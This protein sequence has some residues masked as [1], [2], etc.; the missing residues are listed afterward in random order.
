MDGPPAGPETHPDG[1]AEVARDLG[2]TVNAVYLAR[3][4]VLRRLHQEL[5]GL[6][7]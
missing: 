3:S 2:I 1:G 6:L 4:R 7:D 5:D